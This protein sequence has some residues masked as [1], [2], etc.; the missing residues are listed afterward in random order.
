MSE[1]TGTR[2]GVPELV[3][4]DGGVATAA[5]SRCMSAHLCA[6][7]LT[8]CLAGILSALP[9]RHGL[10]AALAVRDI[11]LQPVASIGLPSVRRASFTVE[12]SHSIFHDMSLKGAPELAPTAAVKLPLGV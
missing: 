4:R 1:S 5:P 6:V 11:R 12:R 3:H 2:P 8:R 9:R 10:H 7:A